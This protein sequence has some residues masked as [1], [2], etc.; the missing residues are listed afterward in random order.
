MRTAGISAYLF[1]ASP[2]L[3]ALAWCLVPATAAVNRTYG[4][5]LAAASAAQQE[6]LAGAASVAADALGAV[7]SACSA[8]HCFCAAHSLK[9]TH[10]LRLRCVPS[11]A[12]ARRRWSFLATGRGAGAPTTPA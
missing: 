9:L 2:R 1:A 7:H 6:A 8:W 4:R 12:A 5:R 10:S 3:G 11:R